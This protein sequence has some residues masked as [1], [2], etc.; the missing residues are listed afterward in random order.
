MTTNIDSSD[1][2]NFDL[3]YRDALSDPS[4][5]EM[6]TIEKGAPERF[7]GKSVDDLIQMHVNL[8]KVLHRQ[9]NELGQARKT[10][11]LQSQ[12]LANAIPRT[13]PIQVVQ[14][15]AQPPLTAETL[16]VDPQKALDQAIRPVATATAQRLDNLE[17]KLSQNDFE[18]KHPDFLKDVQDPEFQTWVAGST[19]R[20]K[21]ISGL[22][23]YDFD[24]GN[25]LWELWNEHK[26]AQQSVQKNIADKTKAATTVKS[27]PGEPVGKPVYSRA[28]LAELQIRAMNGDM[29]AKARWEDPE[30]QKE[31]LS[32]YAEDRIK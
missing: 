23:Q 25:D 26:A 29:A 27:S 18:A 22:N 4:N 6:Q 9:G 20:K 31:Y 13:N 8:E 21:L 7:K 10:I 16:L 2:S 1:A 5:T 28:K 12:A 15:Q 32:A 30:F 14:P 3:E 24:A 19:A 11:D 17:K